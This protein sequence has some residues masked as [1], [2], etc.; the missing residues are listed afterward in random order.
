MIWILKQ[1]QLQLLRPVTCVGTS[2]NFLKKVAKISKSFIEISITCL[3]MNNTIDSTFAFLHATECVKLMW[4]F[5]HTIHRLLDHLKILI[6]LSLSTCTLSGTWQTESYGET[7]TCT[8]LHGLCS[9]CC[10]LHVSMKP[11]FGNFPIVCLQSTWLRSV[12]SDNIAVLP[13][14]SHL[15]FGLA[16]CPRTTVPAGFH[17]KLIVDTFGRLPITIRQPCM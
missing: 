11:Q 15:R 9:L 1:V 10:V 6:Q 7:R 17:L 8:C 14:Q 12:D 2:L 4:I 16:D 5:Y 3:K 13:R